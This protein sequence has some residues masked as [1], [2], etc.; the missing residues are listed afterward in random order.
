[1]DR[2]DEEGATFQ[3]PISGGG[4]VPQSASR[5]RFSTVVGVFDEVVQP[6]TTFRELLIGALTRSKMEAAEVDEYLQPY[7]GTAAPPPRLPAGSPA[8]SLPTTHHPLHPSICLLLSTILPAPTAPPTPVP[9]KVRICNSIDF[10]RTGSRP[11]SQLSRFV[12]T[13]TRT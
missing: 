1:M 7:D 4:S 8:A 6:E 2:E 10:K 11:M 12:C 13:P 9:V 3:V 5:T